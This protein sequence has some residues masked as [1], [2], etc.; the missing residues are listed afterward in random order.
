MIIDDGANTY[1]VVPPE[2]PKPPQPA[3][4]THHGYTRVDDGI[5][6]LSPA[7]QAT[8]D[9]MLLDRVLAKRERAWE[10]SDELRQKLREA[11]VSVNDGESTYSLKP[12]PLPKAPKPPPPTEH[13]YAREEAD[14]GA[15]WASLP[16]EHRSAIDGL[17]LARLQAKKSRQWEA[18]DAMRSQLNELGVYVDDGRKVWQLLLGTG[19]SSPGQRFTWPGCVVGVQ[20]ARQGGAVRRVHPRPRRRLRRRAQRDGRGDAGRPPL[21]PPAG[22]ALARL[23]RR[24]RHP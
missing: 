4:P 2:P 20:A 7:D 18:A 16:A 22:A 15:A 24:R 10:R 13:D 3:R 21:R 14:G 5:V 19:R 8:L 6:V 23:R 9:G 1:R 12:P 17:L 11:G